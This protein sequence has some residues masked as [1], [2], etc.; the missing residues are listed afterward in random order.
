L[1]EPDP[2]NTVLV[3]A[4]GTAFELAPPLIAPRTAL[5]RTVK[6]AAQAISEV[7]RTRNL[8]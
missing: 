1:I 4:I 2:G 6:I 5:D 7:A 3:N 8:G